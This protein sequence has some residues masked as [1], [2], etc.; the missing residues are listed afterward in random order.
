MKRKLKFSIIGSLLLF[1]SLSACFGGGDISSSP[2]YSFINSK[3]PIAKNGDEIKLDGILDEEIYDSLRWYEE[4]YKTASETVYFRMTSYFDEFGLYFMFDIDDPS[5]YV[6][7]ERESYQNSGIELYA[8]VSTAYELKRGAFEIDLVADGTINMKKAY[9]SGFVSIGFPFEKAPIY[10]VKTKGGPVNSEEI[11]GY[12]SELF[13]PYST[14]GLED[15]PEYVYACPT[16]LR[17]YSSNP[18]DTDRL[19]YNF[20]EQTKPDWSWHNPQTW[21]KYK[22]SGFDSFKVELESQGNGK[23][24]TDSVYVYNGGSSKVYISPNQGYRLKTL[25]LN[26]ESVIND[27]TIFENKA[28]YIINRISED[29]KLEAEFEPIPSQTYKVSGSILFDNNIIGEEIVNDLEVSL[30]SGGV[31]YNGVI[32]SD[33][34]YEATV[35]LGNA[36]IVIYSTQDAYIVKTIKDVSVTKDTSYDL[37]IE[38]D[39]YGKT[40]VITMFDNSVKGAAVG[41]AFNSELLGVSVPNQM[42]LSSLWFYDQPLFNED[43]TLILDPTYGTKANSWLELQQVAWLYDSQGNS[44]GRF[45]YMLVHWNESWHFKLCVDGMCSESVMNDDQIRLLSAG[46][47]RVFVS[48]DGYNFSFYA[49]NGKGEIVRVASVTNGARSRYMKYIDT[50]QTSSYLDYEFKAIDGKVYPFMTAPKDVK[51]DYYYVGSRSTPINGGWNLGNMFINE[52][53]IYDRYFVIASFKYENIIDENNVIRYINEVEMGYR[54]N[55]YNGDAWGKADLKLTCIDNAWY[56]DLENNRT[57]L[58]EK[59]ITL[60]ATTGLDT[61]LIRNNDGTASVY[62]DDGNGKMTKVITSRIENNRLRYLDILSNKGETN[63]GTFRLSKVT[64]YA[65]YDSSLTNDDLINLLFN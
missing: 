12:T 63:G 58:S 36:N 60:I 27:L 35:P 8:A 57:Q 39:E 14:F 44:A 5:I 49:D 10:K 31:V 13:I 7:H 51:F 48:Q 53:G 59:Q 38:L 6:N 42:V 47:L 56:I 46:G 19:W 16:L 3:I 15:K 32:N 61:I 25:T 17:T 9:S 20:G 24:T 29:V 41:Q 22:E 23:L 26:G 62:I 11:T 30:V 54:F 43:G 18:G 40:R 55:V 34:T 50:K 45:E 1:L 37:K 28:T 64:V 65:N 52:A 21:W 4:T 2:I 33:G